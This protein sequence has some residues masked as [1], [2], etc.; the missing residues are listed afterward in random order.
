MTLLAADLAPITDVIT[1]NGTL[2]VGVVITIAA[3]Y[4]LIKLV[5]R[6]AR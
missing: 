6:V 2:L 4:F 1:D 3:F 5:K